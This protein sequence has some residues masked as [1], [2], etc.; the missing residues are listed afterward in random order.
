MVLLDGWQH[1]VL[2]PPSRSA[3]HVPPAGPPKRLPVL[4]VLGGLL[5]VARRTQHRQGVS[6]GRLR[7]HMHRRRRQQGV[8]AAAVAAVAQS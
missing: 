4:H 2:A 6:H 8:V 1:D 7:V 5:R 3:S